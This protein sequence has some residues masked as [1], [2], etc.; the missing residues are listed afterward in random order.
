MGN[1][2]ELIIDLKKLKS[3]YYIRMKKINMILNKYNKTS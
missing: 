3:K 2:P 1:Y